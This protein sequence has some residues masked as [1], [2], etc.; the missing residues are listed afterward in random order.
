[1]SHSTLAQIT[2]LERLPVADLQARWRDLIGMDPPRYNRD[3]LIKRLAYRLQELT[4]GGLSAA[5]QAKMKDI[6]R[7]ARRCG[8]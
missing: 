7:E 5:T 1:M 8:L 3:F 6:L 4:H 2:E